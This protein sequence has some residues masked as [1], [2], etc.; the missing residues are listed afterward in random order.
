MGQRDPDEYDRALRRLASESGVHKEAALLLGEKHTEAL[1]II[2]ALGETLSKL[3][4]RSTGVATGDG[5]LLYEE[6]GFQA[7]EEVVK[8]WHNWRDRA[9]R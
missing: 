5:K 6:P 8:R 4:D 3:L 2:A 9:L 7:A 1:Q